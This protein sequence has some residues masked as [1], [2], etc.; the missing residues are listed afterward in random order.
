MPRSQEAAWEAE[1]R[2]P[3]ML[4]RKNVPHADV[5][6]FVRTLKKGARKEGELLDLM[7]WRVLDLGSGT[8]RNAFY[9][10]EQGADVIGYEFSETALELAQ[11]FAAHAEL[12][13]TYENRDIG[14]PYPLPDASVDLVLDVT[15]S[16][17]LGVA[18]RQV[19]LGEVRRVL[20]SG[21]HM[22]VR[23]LCKDGDQHAKYL[24]KHAPGPEPDTYLHPDLQL[25]E[26]VFTEADFRETYGTYLDIVSLERSFHYATVAGRRYKRAYWLA[27]LIKPYAA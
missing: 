27:H 7:G 6:R 9:L 11:K 26:K 2:K 16:N 23:A 10:A 8:G 13:I 14:K 4:T 17:S 19:Y 1:Y 18:G 3:L 5:V 25:C 21:G 15:S 20:K 24:V 12:P 22:F